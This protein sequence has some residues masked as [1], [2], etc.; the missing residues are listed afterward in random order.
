M[1]SLFD[2][3]FSE[4]DIALAV[5]MVVILIITCVVVIFKVGDNLPIF[6]TFPSPSVMDSSG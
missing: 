5:C 6:T 1:S 4:D 3:S 2:N